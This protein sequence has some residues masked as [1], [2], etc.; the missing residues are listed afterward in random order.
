[1]L[2]IAYFNYDSQSSNI[3]KCADMNTAYKWLCG[4]FGNLFVDE[5][6]S[7]LKE[8]ILVLINEHGVMV[9][10]IEI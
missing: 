2:V 3:E 4:K 5:P 9:E 1:M 6:P 8:L 10:M 7:T